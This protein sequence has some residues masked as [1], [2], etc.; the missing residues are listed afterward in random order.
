MSA[1]SST[2]T[3]L[4]KPVSKPDKVIKG[5]KWTLAQNKEYI[6]YYGPIIWKS[7]Q[8]YEFIERDWLYKYWKAGLPK[9]HPKMHY[10]L[11][12]F[13]HGSGRMR[14]VGPES[15]RKPTSELTILS[16]TRQ[17]VIQNVIE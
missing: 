8:Y 16:H 13:P 5:A 4:S 7:E 6:F 1:I 3:G 10:Y 15:K 2:A 11:N 17:I 14:P 12:I 9:H